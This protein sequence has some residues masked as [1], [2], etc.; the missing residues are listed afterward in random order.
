MP[1]ISLRRNAVHE[2]L[3]ARV[4]HAEDELNVA[5]RQQGAGPESDF[6]KHL[7]HL[8][9]AELE[10]KDNVLDKFATEYPKYMG[11]RRPR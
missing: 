9:L 6:V 11:P 2:E 10:Y 8:Y 1:T 5:M 7:R 4:N 3:R